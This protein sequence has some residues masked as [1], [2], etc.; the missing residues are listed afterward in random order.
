MKKILVITLIISS[1]GFSSPTLAAE[2]LATRLSGRILLQV[3]S[4][5]R[6]WYIEPV[7]LQRYYL[8]DGNEAYALMRNKGLGI[9][10]ADLKKIPTQA[11]QTKDIKL[12]NRLKGR[13]L[14]QVQQRGEAWYVNPVDGLRYYLKDGQAAYDLMRK[15]GLGIKNSDLSQIKMNA[16]QIVH[17]TT[18]NDVAYVYFDGQSF[19]GGY[20]ADQILPLASL[21]KLMTAL[22]FLDTN[23]NWNKLVTI[24]QEQI[25]YPKSL[26]GQDASSEVD[27]AAGDTVTIYDLWVAMLVA[28]SNQAA[29]AVADASGLSRAEFVKKM[30]TK[31][32]DLG[33]VKTKFYDVSG[34]DSHNITTAKEMA[35]LAYAAFANADI[36]S[37]GQQSAYVIGAINATSTKQ[38]AV[39]DRN[40]SLQQFFPD[41]SK[42]GFL[43]EAQRTVA[44]KKN[45]GVAVVLHAL[46]MSQRNAALKKL[47]GL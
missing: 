31:A 44:V 2:D 30:N 43:V 16:E 28:S 12:V 27:L 9:S 5:G 41:A 6:A 47:L 8:S 39:T 33:L 23:P 42:T 15:M 1:F 32:S 14:L 38:I 21:T 25:N 40:Y 37:A 35:K 45:G 3:E 34:L 46:S 13:I 4:Y 26:V 10:D 36:I 22:V 29:V 11:G 18:F 24:T 17:D 20:N 19:S 7:S